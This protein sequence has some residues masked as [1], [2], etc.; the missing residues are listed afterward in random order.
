MANAQQWLD[1]NYPLEKRKD[2]KEI[3]SNQGKVSGLISSFFDGVPEN[4]TG[5]FTNFQ[6]FDNLAKLCLA[7]RKIELKSIYSLPNTLEFLQLAN[8][9]FPASTLEPFSH[10]IN[11]VH[12][13]IGAADPYSITPSFF[14]NMLSEH[15]KWFGSLK[16]LEKLTK[17]ESVCLAT[18][19]VNEGLEYLSNT[20]RHVGCTSD[21]NGKKCLELKKI[22][23]QFYNV[24]IY[25]MYLTNSIN[26]IRL[27]EI[28][29]R[30]ENNSRLPKHV[31]NNLPLLKSKMFNLIT[32]EAG[33]INEQNNFLSIELNSVNEDL[34]HYKN[35]QEQAI[36]KLK[37]SLPLLMN[38]LDN[39]SSN[40]L[41]TVPNLEQLRFTII[42]L[43]TEVNNKSYELNKLSNLVKKCEKNITE[44][45]EK[46]EELETWKKSNLSKLNNFEAIKISLENKNKENDQL[47]KALKEITNKYN[48][49][50][51]LNMG[52]L[53]INSS[54]GKY[55]IREV[56]KLPFIQISDTMLENLNLAAFVGK[57][58]GYPKAQYWFII[59]FISLSTINYIFKIIKFSYFKGLDIFR[60]MNGQKKDLDTLKETELQAWKDK[61]NVAK[62]YSKNSLEKVKSDKNILDI[63]DSENKKID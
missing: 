40:A 6:G 7:E 26:F 18:S 44:N 4:L 31:K 33:K 29:E 36:K 37:I 9:S 13:D 46:I 19:D 45:N 27:K 59:F 24:E 16:P 20:V 2:I 5:S 11:L 47:L 63:P 54:A 34:K 25:K 35:S 14:N 42:G 50:W 58:A 43:E 62:N 38:N 10:L 57:G 56:N 61:W 48:W 17:L 52:T 55:A 21:I 30:M 22:W 12:L 1:K 51:R 53:F 49:E 32:E 41:L 8:N 39:S 60:W 3:G 28:F 23:G 15:N